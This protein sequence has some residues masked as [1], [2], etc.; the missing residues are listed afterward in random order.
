[1]SASR[2]TSPF[3]YTASLPIPDPH[4]RFLCRPPY[5]IHHLGITALSFICV[6]GSSFVQ[7]ELESRRDLSFDICNIAF[8]AETAYTYERL[9]VYFYFI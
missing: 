5:L 9:F 7:I 8:V 6:K 1:M 4:R 2:Q 3:F